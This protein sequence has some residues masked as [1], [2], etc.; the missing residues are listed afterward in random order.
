MKPGAAFC[1]C[2]GRSRA[3]RHSSGAQHVAAHRAPILI[4]MPTLFL[5]TMFVFIL[6]RLLPGD[7]VLVMAG[8]ERDPEVLAVLREMYRLN[9][10]IPVQYLAWV[11]NALQGDLGMSLRTNQPVLTLIGQKL[12][13]TIQ[14]AADGDDHR[15]GD[16]HPDGRP[17]GVRRA[18]GRLPG[19]HRRACRG[20]RSRTSGSA[21]C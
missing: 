18:P 13:V 21:S 5:V 6:Q 3:P 17:V 16:R 1:A 9:D 14:L 20:C 12:P 11:G 2:A 10:P 19:Q 15:A 4:A 7:P 8:E